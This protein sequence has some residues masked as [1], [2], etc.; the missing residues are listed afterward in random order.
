MNSPFTT[1]IEDVTLVGSPAIYFSNP[2]VFKFTILETNE[3]FYSRYTDP[4][5]AYKDFKERK[6]RDLLFQ[7]KN[8]KFQFGKSDYILH[9]D[10]KNKG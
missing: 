3:T 2:P 4:H 1:K 6:A 10:D 5:A 8:P 7:N 9:S